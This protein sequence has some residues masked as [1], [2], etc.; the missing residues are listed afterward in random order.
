MYKGAAGIDAINVAMQ[1]QFNSASINK[2]ELKV[3]TTIFRE[4]DKVMLLKNLPEED[5][6]NGD[7]GYIIEIDNSSKANQRISVDFGNRIVDFT[8]DFLFYLKHAYCISV[9]KAQGS[10]YDTVCCVVDQN[11]LHML[12]KRLL[13]TGISRAKKQL[14]IIGQRYVF[15]KQVRLKNRRIRQTT[16]KK[17]IQDY[18]R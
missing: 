14:F 12:E 16:L 11:S 15:E 1:E 3:G 17:R 7:I 8:Y 6:Y 18:I 9:H 2:Q 5:V 4:D 10:E 13:Y